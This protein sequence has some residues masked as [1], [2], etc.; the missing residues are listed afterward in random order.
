MKK[1]TLILAI[2]ALVPPAVFAM[3]PVTNFFYLFQGAFLLFCI[4]SCLTWCRFF[5]VLRSRASPAVRR[6]M[7]W[8]TPLVLVASI[9][10]IGPLMVHLRLL[11]DFTNWVDKP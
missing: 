9:L 1:T 10:P 3:P 6:Q 7:L 11:P 4:V 5:V 8:L 2:A